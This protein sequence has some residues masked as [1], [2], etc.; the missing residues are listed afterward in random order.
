MRAAWADKRV[1]PGCARPPPATTLRPMISRSARH[2]AWRF[3]V[4]GALLGLTSG[5]F[6]FSS[7]WGKREE[8]QRHRAERLTPELQRSQALAPA[9][10]QRVLTIRAYATEAYRA[11]TL[12]W[13]QRIR[14]AM[15]EI[16][17]MLTEL[18]IRVIVKDTQEWVPRTREDDLLAL[19]DELTVHDAA[20]DVDWVV[21][22]VGSVPRLTESFH[23]LGYAP[24]LGRHFVIRAANNLERQQIDE[25]FDELDESERSRLYERRA[26]HRFASLFLHELAHTLGAPHVRKPEELMFPSYSAD[27]LGFG[28]PTIGLLKLGLAERFQDDTQRRQGFA[29][30]A[31]LQHLKTHRDQWADGDELIT[32]IEQLL[33]AQTAP[34]QTTPTATATR[35]SAD[36]GH[37]G[38][39][40]NTVPTSVPVAAR[41]D[42][43]RAHTALEAQRMDEAWSLV[44]AYPQNYP[45]AELLCSV[46]IRRGLA[47]DALQ[48]RCQPMMDMATR[49][50]GAAQ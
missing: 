26:V 19:L 36:P 15:D 47:G 21:G 6:F 44:T 1:D 12:G 41:D 34:A 49:G 38:S 4:I 50:E 10:G 7:E 30:N 42:F 23:D 20:S 8:A 22:L 9:T 27:M 3:W 2:A 32:R 45:I 17:P 5:C 29:L 25:A 14:Q 46:S 37:T 43:A 24:V 39:A 11:R 16:N 28:P 48:Q 40:S 35:P 13:S 31:M 18:G 33:A